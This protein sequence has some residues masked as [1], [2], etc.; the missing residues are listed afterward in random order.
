MDIE[1]F[2]GR[3]T[4]GK[5]QNSRWADVGWWDH[6]KMKMK[7]RA[8]MFAQSMDLWEFEG[9]VLYVLRVSCYWRMAVWCC[10]WITG[11]RLPL[12][13][14]PWE[15]L[16][17]VAL[18]FGYILLSVWIKR[19]ILLVSPLIYSA[20]WICIPCTSWTC[21]INFIS[22][23]ILSVAIRKLSSCSV[24]TSFILF[25]FICTIEKFCYSLPCLFH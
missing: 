17:N 22:C 15:G 10:Y 21:N 25:Y 9:F 2:I 1:H 14:D 7:S 16:F 13:F 19:V 3:R 24:T 6:R 23:C 12:F 8:S 11:R 20:W 18:V 5:V 4:C